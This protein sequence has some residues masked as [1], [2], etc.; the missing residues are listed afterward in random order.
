MTFSG[1]DDNGNRIKTR[2]GDLRKFGETYYWYGGTQSDM[3]RAQTCYSSTDLVNW[4][5]R[6][7]AFKSPVETN[8]IDVLYNK[9][10]EHM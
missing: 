3:H 9:S 10:T 1:A 2:S 4:K 8:R 5:S 7:V 6:G